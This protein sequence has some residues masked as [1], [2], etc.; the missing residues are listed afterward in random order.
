M[1]KK[2]IKTIVSITCGLGIATAI[3]IIATSCNDKKHDYKIEINTPSEYT[4]KF[5]AKFEPDPKSW[6]IVSNTEFFNLSFSYIDKSININDYLNV[7][8]IR[9]V[10]VNKELVY[11][12]TIEFG[13][14]IK[15]TKSVLLNISF[16][17]NLS[18]TDP[19]NPYN[20]T[21]CLYF[22]N[23]DEKISN[24]IILDYQVNFDSTIDQY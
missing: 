2:L 17:I 11:I 23:Y 1:N 22:S 7:F 8:Y 15:E 14:Y 4:S 18:E 20:G 6:W 9:C 24:E 16:D 21:L 10:D 19:L 13:N 5:N 3:P 12:P